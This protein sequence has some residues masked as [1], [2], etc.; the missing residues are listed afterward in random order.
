M[1]VA[2]VLSILLAVASAEKSLHDKNEADETIDEKVEILMS[3]IDEHCEAVNHGGKL[4]LTYLY[5]LL[6]TT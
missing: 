2:V 3:K 5:Y 4:V 6:V 1:R